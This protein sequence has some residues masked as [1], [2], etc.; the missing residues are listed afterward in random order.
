[1]APKL[2]RLSYFGLPSS[3]LE[4]VKQWDPL[5]ERITAVERGESGKEWVLQH[6]LLLNAFRLGISQKLTLLRGDIDR[7]LI[8]GKDLYGNYPEWPYD[9][10]SLDYSGGLF[11]KDSAGKLTRLEAIRRVFQHESNAGATDFVLLL[12]FNIDQVDQHEVRESLKVIQRELKR[13]GQA[14]NEVIDAYLRHPKEQSR[15]KLYTLRLISTLAVESNFESEGDSPILY[16]GNRNTEMMAFRFYLKKST[17][18]FAP[19]P[20]RERLNQVVNKRMIEIVKGKQVPTN[21]KLP[22]LKGGNPNDD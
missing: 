14:A 18:T 9:I 2:G 1:M 11:Y 5:L 7:I 19:R 15:L 10:V 4:D 8:T 20:P 17:R 13:F 6:E 22:L 3:S 21:L 12:S 16:L